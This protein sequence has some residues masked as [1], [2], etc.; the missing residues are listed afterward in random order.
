[1]ITNLPTRCPPSIF[2][3]KVLSSINSPVIFTNWVK[4][5]ALSKSV[6]T[7]TEAVWRAPIVRFPDRTIYAHENY[8]D[9]LPI[10]TS[11][12][13][14]NLATPL[15]PRWS[16]LFRAKFFKATIIGGTR[17]RMADCIRSFHF[18]PWRWSGLTKPIV[19]LNFLFN[20]F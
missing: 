8:D 17:W 13:C 1:M 7:N 3:M 5:L 18:I 11:I 2:A 16:Q 6:L 15:K 4:H 14:P 12:L 9:F 19:S 10:S 20:L